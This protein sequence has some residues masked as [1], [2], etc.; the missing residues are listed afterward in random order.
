[1]GIYTHLW[2]KQYLLLAFMLLSSVMPIFAADD[3]LI[4]EQVT[5]DINEYGSLAAAIGDKKDKITNLKIEGIC[6][7][8]DFDFLREMKDHLLF[9]DFTNSLL[10]PTISDDWTF[11]DFKKLQQIALPSSLLTKIG[12]GAFRNC[13]SLTSISIPDQV[14]QI[15]DEAFAGCNSLASIKIP[16]GITVIGDKAFSNCS[17]LTSVHF[18]LGLKQIGKEAFSNC[19]SLTSV[20]IP[21]GLSE[22][23]DKTFAGCK[24]LENIYCHE[25]VLASPTAFD[26]VDKGKCTVYVPIGSAGTYKENGN[27]N[28]FKN[29]IESYDANLVIVD[30]NDKYYTDTWAETIGNWESKIS[31]LKI[32]GDLWKDDLKLIQEIMGHLQ[33]LDISQ[34]VNSGRYNLSFKNQKKIVKITLPE[35]FTIDKRAF[36]GCYNLKSINIPEGV[37]EIGDSAF[38]YCENLT[39]I[40]LPIKL[41]HIKDGAFYLCENLTSVNIPEGAEIGK[42]AFYGCSK[43]ESINFPEGWK[44]SI[45]AYAFSYCKSLKAVNLPSSSNDPYNHNICIGHHAFKWCTSLA[46]INIPNNTGISDNAFEGCSSLTTI[47]IPDRCWIGNEAFRNCTSLMSVKIPWDFGSNAFEGCSSLT[48][49]FL[50]KRTDGKDGYVGDKAFLGCKKIKSIYCQGTSPARH[51]DSFDPGRTPFEQIVTQEGT[52]YVPIGSTNKYRQT[53]W[54]EFKNIV[55]Y[56]FD[57]LTGIDKV[58]TDSDN[59]GENS[60]V[61]RYSINGQRLNAPTQGLNIVKYSDGTTKKVMVP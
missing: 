32:I 35:W 60:E 43:L 44:G 52:L 54:K 50:K 28:K 51:Y 49:V 38:S 24:S 56:D 9:L 61:A 19:S 18:P 26:G 11:S 14:T 40:N 31:N 23:N 47:N 48:T 22:I 5:V 12:S 13:S 34:T 10:I 2:K 27:W 8:S 25:E 1:M 29:I 15:G 42:R 21:Y 39:Y 36:S 37:T 16:K 6:Q 46:S 45:D 57:K 55:E 4:A 58:T 53:E 3:D 17:S 33:S 30:L 41:K 20:R 59:Q 7:D